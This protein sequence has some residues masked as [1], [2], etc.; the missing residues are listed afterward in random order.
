MIRTEII[1]DTQQF[2]TCFSRLCRDYK[3]LRFAVAWCGDPSD[4]FPYTY[5]ECV[6]G[7]K[8]CVIGIDFFHSHPKGIRRLVSS[9]S[10][11]RIAR[12]H[13]GVFH[14]KIYVFE[15]RNSAAI[16]I[17][18]SNLTKAGF[19]TN[20]EAAFLMEGGKKSLR[21]Q[22]KKFGSAFERWSS[23]K[24]SIQFTEKWLKDYA[25]KHARIRRAFLKKARSHSPALADENASTPSSF[26]LSA[27]WQ[28]YFKKVQEN[29]MRDAAANKAKQDNW[30][31]VIQFAD[32]ILPRR[33]TYKTFRNPNIRALLLG[34]HRKER[35]LGAFGHV[36]VARN[37]RHILANGTKSEKSAIATALNQVMSLKGP[38]DIPSLL[39]WLRQLSRVGPTFKVWG[40]FLL[41]VH[42]DLFF[43]VSANHLR[44]NLSEALNMTQVEF[45]SPSGYLEAT[46]RIH[47]SPWFN[48][49]R[50][51]GKDERFVWDHRAAFVDAILR[52]A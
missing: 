44:R 18:S 52:D 45:R 37:L 36:G 12:N 26:L 42:P 1:L 7:S 19:S 6:R 41:L 20:E 14:P 27:S 50:P 47:G 40:R 30:T 49:P 43:T 16:L 35:D 34:T 46:N 51:K 9:C 24:Y 4:G 48:S 2:S 29:R 8:D 32:G 23:T 33:W 13:R 10:S 5:L 28:Q 25:R 38:S 11:V 3:S 17:G 21:T 22:L 39:P 31:K 15:K